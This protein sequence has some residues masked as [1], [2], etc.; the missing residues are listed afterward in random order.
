MRT[1]Q[2]VAV[3]CL[4]AA[5][6]ASSVI[7]V[8]GATDRAASGDHRT[9]DERLSSDRRACGVGGPTDDPARLPNESTA[10]WAA[11]GPDRSVARG[12]V[13]VLD[14]SVESNATVRVE[15]PTGYRATLRVTDDGDG[16]VRLGVNTLLAGNRTNGTYL[17]AGSDAVRVQNA[18]TQPSFTPGTYTVR[19]TS[20]GSVIDSQTLRVRPSEVGSVTAYRAPGDLFNATDEAVVNR[21]LATDDRQLGGNGSTEIIDGETLVVRLDGA[22]LL[23]GFAADRRPFGFEYDESGLLGR[24]EIGGPC[25]GIDLDASLSEGAARFVPDYESGVVYLLV[26]VQRAAGYVVA[27]QRLDVS[28]TNRQLTDT[29]R[30]LTTEFRIGSLEENVDSVELVDGDEIRI[31]GESNRLSRTIPVRIESRVD[32]TVSIRTNLTVTNGTFERSVSVPADRGPYTVFVAG[33]PHGAWSDDRPRFFW[34]ME[35]STN[36]IGPSELELTVRY[37]SLTDRLLVVYEV[38]R[39]NGTYRPLGADD[40]GTIPIDGRVPV[41]DVVVAVHEDRD[42]DGAFDG[43]A[44]DPVVRLDGPVADWLVGD[45]AGPADG[46]PLPAPITEETV[47]GSVTPTPAERTT[48]AEQTATATDPT[49]TG[50][51]T[52]GFGVVLGLVGL[53]ALAAIARRHVGR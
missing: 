53:A 13:A 46:E 39:A 35:E 29:D 40:D 45:P 19:V 9:D 44:A 4:V 26:D 22:S 43:P 17:A 18:T 41:G 32:P 16:T 34:A 23:G 52:P 24:I 7:A 2:T 3:V 33:E 51:T 49:P 47:V 14:L 28:L 36:T 38:D 21:T 6:A 1:L 20:N 10:G 12:D 25:G 48:T 50:V 8:G 42:G 30:Q 37:G 5:L 31:R 11:A 27:D 15:G